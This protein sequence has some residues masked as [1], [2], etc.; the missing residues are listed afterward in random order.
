MTGLEDIYS[1]RK[2]G[3]PSIPEM[4]QMPN[5]IMNNGSPDLLQA[6]LAM[7]HPVQ[8]FQFLQQQ[9]QNHQMATHIQ[10]QMNPQTRIPQQKT[11]IFDPQLIF[12][13]TFQ[14]LKEF[15]TLG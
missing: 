5:M 10:R 6:Q 11:V 3:L 12:F 15:L 14:E 9:I 7:L 4:T 8:K 2:P 1:L 13:L